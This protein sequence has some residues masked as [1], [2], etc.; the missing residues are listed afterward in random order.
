MD[1][2]SGAVHQFV[3]GLLA[4]PDCTHC[5]LQGER[6]VPPEGNPRARIALVGEAPGGREAQDGRPFV[7]LSGKLLNVFLEQA[8]ISR[9]EVWI[10]NSALCKPKS[11]TVNGVRL[12]PEKVVKIAAEHCRSRL[13]A[14]LRIVRPI[15]IIGL[16]GQAIRSVYDSKASMKGRRGA[17]HVIDLAGAGTPS[18][19]TQPT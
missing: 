7:G 2:E 17:V 8:G 9:H 19:G 13:Q 6:I 15:V 5:P 10:T 4:Q 11:A 16:G 18:S 12:N 14:E 3:S 1:D